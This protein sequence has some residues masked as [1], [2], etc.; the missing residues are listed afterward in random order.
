MRPG[1]C[2]V[3]KA[4]TSPPDRRGRLCVELLEAQ[5]HEKEARA[6]SKSE[7]RP[8]ASHP[9]SQSCQRLRSMTRA[10]GACIRA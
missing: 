1:T 3:W 8:L 10:C 4:G 5:A 7:Q 9:G 2:R 6:E